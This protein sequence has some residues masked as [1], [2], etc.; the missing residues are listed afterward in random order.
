MAMNKDD[1]KNGSTG[2]NNGVSSN[3]SGSNYGM[4]ANGSGAEKLEFKQP[5]ESMTFKVVDEAVTEAKA[6]KLVPVQIENAAKNLPS[7]DISQLPSEKIEGNMDGP[8]NVPYF[9]AEKPKAQSVKPPFA[10]GAWIC[11]FFIAVTAVWTVIPQS[12]TWFDPNVELHK[13]QQKAFLAFSK[14][15]KKTLKAECTQVVALRPDFALAYFGRGYAFFSEETHGA[16]DNIAAAAAIPDFNR[17]AQ[18]APDDYFF[19]AFLG[20]ALFQNS[21]YKQAQTVFEKA[22][23]L[24]HSQLAPFP[25]EDLLI[26]SSEI[27]IHRMLAKCL[28]HEGHHQQALSMY[29]KYPGQGALFADYADEM[30]AYEFNHNPRAALEK[31]NKWVK[32]LKADK[33]LYSHL[34]LHCATLEKSI[35]A[36]IDETGRNLLYEGMAYHGL[37]QYDKSIAKLNQAIALAPNNADCYLF[38]AECYRHTN[39]NDLALA[40]L[41][42]VL[43]L[44]KDNA[45]AQYMSHRWQQ[46][47]SAE[48][49]AS[50]PR[51]WIFPE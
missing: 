30:V 20:L 44:D 45:Y 42:K 3:G 4:R 47:A 37:Q 11:W 39:R 2:N 23:A 19:N 17:A 22:L 1:D 35:D 43:Q 5:G 14:A 13:H 49:L 50:S 33:P 15:D 16:F 10:P 8:P 21:N 38:R 34:A 40:D 28:L 6:G 9:Y 48:N 27:S 31:G 46:S 29:K 18:L 25:F 7:S 24:K 41:N 36:A 51:R 32:Y 12:Y 26:K